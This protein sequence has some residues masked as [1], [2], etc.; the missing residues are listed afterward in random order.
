MAEPKY[1]EHGN[2]IPEPGTTD[3]GTV[4]EE[5]AKTPE[6]LAAEETARIIAKAEAEG[7][8]PEVI[9]AEEEAAEAAR[10]A[11]GGTPK[12]KG[13]E[14]TPAQKRI[15]R[16]VAEKK[17]ETRQKEEAKR[18]ADYYQGVAQGK[19]APAGGPVAPIVSVAPA[20]PPTL[21]NPADFEG[22]IY[23]V[24]YI[25]EHD[26]Y[27]ID[28]AT[29]QMEKRSRERVETERAGAVQNQFVTRMRTAAVDD[30]SIMSMMDDPTFFPWNVP[31]AGTIG[32]LIKESEIAPDILKHLYDH[33]DELDALYR[34]NPLTAAV[35]IG[36]LESKLK[37]TKPNVR[38]ISQA[39][40]PIVTVGGGGASTIIEDEDKLSTKEFMERR[41][42]KQF[43]KRRAQ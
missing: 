18:R 34:M 26:K 9:V 19:V 2:L 25:E 24:K 10:V 43:G 37:G 4:I 36:R 20:G 42:I 23:D 28:T 32:T 41:N 5:G 30:P 17:E 11:A 40:A 7:K 16:L 1:D 39:P 38:K 12:V 8:T 14:P 15:Q 22:G 13:A 29:Y 35:E 31:A 27:L 33:R 6:E 3:S 21:P